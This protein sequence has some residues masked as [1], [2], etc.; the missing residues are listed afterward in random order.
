MVCR[1]ANPTLLLICQ[2]NYLEEKHPTVAQLKFLFFFHA[3]Q[4]ILYHEKVFVVQKLAFK[5]SPKNLF[6]ST[7]TELLIP[8]CLAV[9][10]FTDPKFLQIIHFFCENCIV[11]NWKHWHFKPENY[12]STDCILS[13]RYYV[14][15]LRAKQAPN[16]LSTEKVRWRSKHF[17]L[18]VTSSQKTS[19]TRKIIGE[20]FQTN[21][22]S[23]IL[24][25]EHLVKEHV[26][27]Q[28]FWR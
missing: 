8:L 13:R 14:V 4:N 25:A 11:S 26:S 16:I 19:R 9:I 5:L 7:H 1:R 21:C 24:I 12:L 23:N 2:T 3:S 27:R 17:L 22:S 6:S 20:F 28:Y 15:P 18:F 10:F